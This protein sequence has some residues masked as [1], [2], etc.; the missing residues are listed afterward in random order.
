MFKNRIYPCVVAYT[1]TTQFAEKAI[2]D[3]IHSM[4]LLYGK[5]N[6]SV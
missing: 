4:K 3:I 6:S 5:K 2:N 1:E